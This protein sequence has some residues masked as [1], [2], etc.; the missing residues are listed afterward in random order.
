LLG[1]DGIQESAIERVPCLAVKAV[2]SAAER[3]VGN[4]ASPAA[5]FRV[6]GVGEDRDLLYGL[7]VRRLVGLA[8]DA[9]VVIVE[10]VNQEVVGARA[11]TVHGEAD[12]VGKI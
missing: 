7:L 3:K 12:T 4:R 1:G 11:Q 5:I 10:A 2:G 8:T 9:V 6:I